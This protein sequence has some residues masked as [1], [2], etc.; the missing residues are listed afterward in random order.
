ML[1]QGTQITKIYF[2]LSSSYLMT[3]RYRMQ[4]ML[5][6]VIVYVLQSDLYI[7]HKSIASFSSKCISPFQTFCKE[8]MPVTTLAQLFSRNGRGLIK[9]KY[10]SMQTAHLELQFGMHAKTCNMCSQGLKI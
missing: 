8:K 4:Q 7:A 1:A 2:I 3:L 6:M 9:L 5:A 10:T